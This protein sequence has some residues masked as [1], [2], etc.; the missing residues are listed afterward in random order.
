[1]YVSPEGKVLPCMSMIGMP[2]ESQ[3][4]NMLRT[5]LE[6]ILD[7]SFYMKI[8]SFSIKDY[9]EHNPDCAECEY[10]N[11]CVGGCRAFAIRSTPDDYLGKDMWTCA[12]YKDGWMEKKNELLAQLKEKYGKLE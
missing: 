4:P 9:M 6:E 3:F 1:M 7:K 10:K 2:I 11:K 12:Y 5:P 8:V